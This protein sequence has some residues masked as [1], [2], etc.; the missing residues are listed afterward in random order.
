MK[1]VL[2]IG[3][4]YDDCE[5]GVGG[6]AALLVKKGIKVYKMTLTDNVTNYP[7][8]NVFVDYDSSKSAS[9]EASRI[10]GVEEISDF[11]P[12]RC[13]YLSYSTELMQR[14]ESIILN[15][16]IDT[17]FIHY[18]NDINQ[19]HVEASRIC[20]TASRHCDNILFFQSNGYSLSNDFAPTI[21][22]DISST[23]DLK[24]KALDQYGQ[25]HNRFGRLFEN[26]I[27]RIIIIVVSL[28]FF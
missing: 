7:A 28:T 21:F 15:K 2:I 11:K 27:E 18:R 23:I 3:A 1:N 26:N 10:L 22:F 19:D 24:K 14:V 4:H 9:A 8:N 12:V 17:V 16:K 20:M 13:N 6:T 5:L 25:E